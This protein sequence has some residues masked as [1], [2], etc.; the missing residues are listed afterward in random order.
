M[1]QQSLG[2]VCF[3][4]LIV[5][6]MLAMLHQYNKVIE[7]RENL[8]RLKKSKNSNGSELNQKDMNQVI[9]PH[10]Q[11]MNPSKYIRP[12]V[13]KEEE[14]TQCIPASHHD[15]DN[16]VSRDVQ[17]IITKKHLSHAYQF[18]HKNNINEIKKLNSITEANFIFVDTETSSLNNPHIIQIALID[19][20]GSVLLLSKI[21]YS[22]SISEEA[23]TVH[24]IST[25]NQP[26]YPFPTELEDNVLKILSGKTII[27]YNVEFELKALTTTFTSEKMMPLIEHLRANN[28]CMM[29]AFQ[30][31]FRFHKR[32]S[33]I[34]ACKQLGVEE[35]P[36]HDAKNDALMLY[37]LYQKIKVLLPNAENWMLGFE[38]IHW[39]NLNILDGTELS[40]WSSSDNERQCLYCPG[41]VMGSGKV[42][43]LG[44]K[45]K[46]DLGNFGQV[47]FFISN[48]HGIPNISMSTLSIS[49]A[50][51]N[52]A[53]DRQKSHDSYQNQLMNPKMPTKGKLRVNLTLNCQEA[54]LNRVPA[55]PEMSI[56]RP[57]VKEGD[58]LYIQSLSYSPNFNFKEVQ[59]LDSTGQSCG[60]LSNVTLDWTRIFGVLMKG[61]RAEV[62]IIDT[63]KRLKVDV[64]FIKNE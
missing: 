13:A 26:C 39:Q 20:T 15:R 22:G 5:G 18:K 43:E 9:S 32:K 19:I 48:M 61:Y 58:I 55:L 50:R 47:S 63:S 3:L 42:A 31:L 60:H 62:H 10:P 23:Q 35:L 27:A 14:K 28:I 54:N 12:V 64:F 46:S 25:T 17:K 7:S 59:F 16:V 53:Y 2:I 49:E 57:Y 34:N 4:L 8:E 40:Y 33:L 56:Y 6:C 37:S 24:G 30:E 36:A 41:S 1:D 51:E 21:R 11:D 45:L 29:K 44:E 38:D 52:H